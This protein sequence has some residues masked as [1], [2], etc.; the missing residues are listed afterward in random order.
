MEEEVWRPPDR[1][2][3][4][5]VVLDADYASWEETQA[6]LQAIEAAVDR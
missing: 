3:E 5:A 2:G 6:D 1:L 4:A